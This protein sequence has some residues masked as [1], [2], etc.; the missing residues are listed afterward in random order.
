MQLAF[1]S[2]VREPCQV[3]VGHVFTAHDE[4]VVEVCLAQTQVPDFPLVCV[5]V[6]LCNLHLTSMLVELEEE[7]IRV[8]GFFIEE[9]KKGDMLAC[10]L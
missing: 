5:S 4:T 9:G 8:S 2:L 6:K 1:K 7:G 10:C 3:K